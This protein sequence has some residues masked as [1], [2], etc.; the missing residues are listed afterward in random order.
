MARRISKRAIRKVIEELEKKD[1]VSDEELKEIIKAAEMTAED[2]VQR[3]FEKWKEM[4][5]NPIL[6][7]CKC[8]YYWFIDSSQTDWAIAMFRGWTCPHCG[9][10]HPWPWPLRRMSE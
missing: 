4:G 6:L 5:F 7:K 8:G 3:D 10:V 2:Q 1:I 9:R